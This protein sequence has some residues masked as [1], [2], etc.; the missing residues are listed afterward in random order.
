VRRYTGSRGGRPF[1]CLKGFKSANLFLK[2]H[3]SSL[4]KFRAIPGFKLNNL[5]FYR[6][7]DLMEFV[8]HPLKLL[9]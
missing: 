4:Y 2:K 1:S 7:D 9:K 6:E 3:G 8:K 5:S